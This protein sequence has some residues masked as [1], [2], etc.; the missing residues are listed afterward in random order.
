M[1]SQYHRTM[2]HIADHKLIADFR[3]LA[4]PILFRS[5]SAHRLYVKYSFLQQKARLRRTEE[6]ANKIGL[7]LHSAHEVAAAP[8]K[9]YDACHII[10]SG[11][12]LRHSLE[13]LDQGRDFV[14]GFNFACLAQTHFNLY[15]VEFG[16]P[17]CADITEAQVAALDHFG[18]PQGA[19]VYFKNLWQEKNDLAYAAKAYGERVLFVRDLDVACALKRYLYDTACTLL[20]DDPEYLRQ[21]SSTALTAVALARRMGFQQIVLHGVDFGGAYF[22]DLPEFAAVARYRPPQANKA[23]YASTERRGGVHA[24]SQKPTG[25]AAIIPHLA[26]RLEEEGIGLYAAAVESPLSQLLPVYERA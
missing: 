24:T 25:M 7:K 10:G 9:R 23:A 14:V 3:R 4:G 21:Y 26:S 1:R 19:D 13:H 17:S 11:W 22:F 6:Q 18:V 15:F 16:G 12:S 2:R 5:H 20:E 8:L